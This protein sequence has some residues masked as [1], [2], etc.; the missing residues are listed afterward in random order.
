MLHALA[1]LV[2]IIFSFGIGMVTGAC[3]KDEFG[4]FDHED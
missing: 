3:W 2:V 1:L 4:K